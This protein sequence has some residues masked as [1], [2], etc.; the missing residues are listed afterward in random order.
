MAGM[1]TAYGPLLDL[2]RGARRSTDRVLLEGVHAVKHALRFGAETALPPDPVPNPQLTM[3]RNVIRPVVEQIANRNVNAETA[4][5]V[6]TRDRRQRDRGRTIPA[7]LN[8]G[9]R[10]LARC[11]D[12]ERKPV[13]TRL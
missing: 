11:L 8:T 1:S 2:V 7:E 4:I 9:A 10:T 5:A 13:I 6:I 3:R 12:R